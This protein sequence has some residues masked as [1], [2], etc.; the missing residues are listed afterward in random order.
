MDNTK[1]KEAY[2]QGIISILV[3]TLLFVA[4][5]YVGI[6]SGSVALV[7]DAWH[8]ISDSASSLVLIIGTRL[9]TKP[10][11]EEHPYGHGRI[12]LITALI[13]GI[14]LALVGFNFLTSAI[15]K[16]VNHQ[17][18]TF[19]ALAIIVTIASILLNEGL[20][21]YAFY[22]GRK[23]GNTSI[24]AD[25]WHHR[26][27][28]LSSL[29]ILVGILVGQQWWWMDG[30]LGIIMA[31]FI[32]HAGYGIFKEVISPLIGQQPE[33]EMVEEVRKI[34]LQLA[35]KDVLPHHFHIHQYGGHTE[36][37]FHIVLDGNIN[38]TEAHA[39]A[40]S[41]EKEINRTLACETTI[42]IDP[43]GETDTLKDIAADK[44]K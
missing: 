2:R 5:Y 35:G 27:D 12:E 25:G 34:C 4:K 39:L 16:L 30:V 32:F 43:E 33:K 29:I 19:G 13:I 20:A 26:S 36:L 3:N 1:G 38:L 9:S 24:K 41:I 11:D 17:A 14:L 22:L 40:D 21:Q 31:A 28:A 15:N 7:T 23:T 42:H 6:I 8:T 10:A 44:F 37:T 18:A